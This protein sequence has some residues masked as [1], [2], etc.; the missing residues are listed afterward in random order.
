MEKE[1]ER[2]WSWGGGH[3]LTLLNFNSNNTIL[4]GDLYTRTQMEI[5]DRD[6]K[7]CGGI[8]VLASSGH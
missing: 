2:E 1:E 7:L 3:G 5:R 6:Q 4:K 8:L